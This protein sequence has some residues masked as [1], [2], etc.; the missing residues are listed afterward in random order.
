MAF[1]A[2]VAFVAKRT[3]VLPPSLQ[4]L[5]LNSYFTHKPNDSAQLDSVS[6]YTSEGS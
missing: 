1:T 2:S 5:V 6:G 3:L 4:E